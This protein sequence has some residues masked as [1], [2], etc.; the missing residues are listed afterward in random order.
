M[1][2][3][4]KLGLPWFYGLTLLGLLSYKKTNILAIAVGSM[5]LVLGMLFIIS[6]LKSSSIYQPTPTIPQSKQVGGHN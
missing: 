4:F 3:I 1:H 2:L 6:Q 5:V